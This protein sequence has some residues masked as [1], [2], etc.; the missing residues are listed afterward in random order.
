M[1]DAIKDFFEEHLFT[2]M[3]IIIFIMLSCATIPVLDSLIQEA[4]ERGKVENIEKIE[5][6]SIAL[7]SDIS[8]RFYLGCGRIEEKEYYI[9]YKILEDGAKM[10]Y[11]MDA[12]KTKIYETLGEDETAYAEE[13]RDG[14]DFLKE[15]KLYIPKN[16]IKQEYNLSLN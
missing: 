14:Y 7:D 9:A 13:I 1:K 5:L 4:S 2:I 16:T 3:K 10:I 12:A 8:G 6:A 15:I 11:K